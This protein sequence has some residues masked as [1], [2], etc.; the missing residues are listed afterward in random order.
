MAWI[1]C[2]WLI[3]D[4]C[5]LMLLWMI[6]DFGCGWMSLDGIGWYWIIK[7][8]IS[9]WA[10]YLYL[11][12]WWNSKSQKSNL[13]M[14][15]VTLGP[16]MVRG[17]GSLFWNRQ[18]SNCFVDRGPFLAMAWC[19]KWKYISVAS[20]SNLQHVMLLSKHTP[21]CIFVPCSNIWQIIAKQGP[22]M[23]CFVLQDVMREV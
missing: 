18:N 21:R 10:I 7:T 1:W 8:I 12:L 4:W 17:K 14:L 13:D 6:I 3:V 15:L 2:I 11:W 20:G 5:W 16:T 22:G 23:K 19:C 9:C